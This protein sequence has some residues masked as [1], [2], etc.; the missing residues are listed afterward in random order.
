MRHASVTV[1]LSFMSAAAVFT[2][3]S[4]SSLAPSPALATLRVHVGLFG[5]PLG[6]NGGMADSNAP[7]PG[8]PIGVKNAAGREWST[9]TRPDGIATF[10]LRPGRYTIAS[11][12][13]GRGPHAV[14]LKAKQRAYVQ[15]RCD[16]P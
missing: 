14:V 3:C 7:Q 6:R 12:L 16:I 11:P 8:A 4:R 15:V 5:G 13:C 9:K 1:M 10:S 2:G